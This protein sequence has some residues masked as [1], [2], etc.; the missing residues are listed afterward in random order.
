MRLDLD[1]HGGLYYCPLDVFTV[2]RLPVRRPAINRSLQYHP[3]PHPESKPLVQY[4]VPVPK[5]AI[6]TSKLLVQRLRSPAPP[7]TLRC[8]SRFTPTS[9]SKQV[10]SEVWLL[11]LGS[12]R[13]HQ[14]DVLPGNVTGLPQVFEYHL[15]RFIDFKEQAQIQKQAAQCLA[16][17]T[18]DC[19]VIIWI[20]ASCVPLLETIPTHK[21]VRIGWFA[22]M[23]V[24]HRTF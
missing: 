10:E 19:D 22:C 4:T 6:N 9:K 17:C 13:V 12:P 3:L 21:R 2:D 18:M 11:R 14:L 1:C 23:T 8:P 24:F 5:M 15:F 16:V 20:L 7:V